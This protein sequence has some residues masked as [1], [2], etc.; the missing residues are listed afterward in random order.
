MSC[1]R[2]SATRRSR[3]VPAAVLIA[4]AAASSHEV[5]LVPMIS[6]TLYTDMALSFDRVRLVRGCCGQPVTER[7]CLSPVQPATARRRLQ[8]LLGD[9]CGVEAF[10]HAASG[11]LAAAS[12]TTGPVRSA[13]ARGLPESALSSRNLPT[14]RDWRAPERTGRCVYRSA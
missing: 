7:P 12:Q 9:R 10:G 13:T 11:S 3:S 8:R 2:T 4:S 14:A 5:L 1:L 6:V